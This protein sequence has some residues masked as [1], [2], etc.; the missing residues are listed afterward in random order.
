MLRIIRGI[1]DVLSAAAP[2]KIAPKEKNRKID[3]WESV[4]NLAGAVSKHAGKQK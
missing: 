3:D 2:H 4:A 1:L